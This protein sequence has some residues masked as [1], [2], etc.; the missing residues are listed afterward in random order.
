MNLCESCTQLDKAPLCESCVREKNAVELR[1]AMSAMNE[2][3]EESTSLLQNAPLQG[4]YTDSAVI[5][6]MSASAS[7]ID[8]VD[9]RDTEPFLDAGSVSVGQI[10]TA[11]PTLGIAS[12][13]ASSSASDLLQRVAQ[14]DTSRLNER[15]LDYDF[16]FENLVLEGGGNKGL[17]YAGVIKVSHTDSYGTLIRLI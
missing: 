6:T 10:I 2:G 16:A 5:P 8:A 9:E 13:V 15:L 12:A 7:D 14:G 4:N 3:L 1:V 11:T 17:A